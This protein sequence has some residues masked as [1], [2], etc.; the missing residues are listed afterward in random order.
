MSTAHLRAV[1]ES[2]PVHLS[3]GTTRNPL[4][5]DLDEN[6]PLLMAVCEGL[7]LLLTAD[8]LDFTSLLNNAKHL[9]YLID[10]ATPLGEVSPAVYVAEHLLVRYGI[11]G[12]AGGKRADSVVSSCRK[13]L[14]PF[15]VEVAWAKPSSLRGAAHLR[16]ADAEDLP[17][18]LA[19]RKKLPAAVVAARRLGK[20]RP[21][22]SCL[23]L[24]LAEAAH[25]VTG[26][27]AVLQQAITD[28]RV[29]TYNDLRTGIALV[30]P[31]S[32]IHI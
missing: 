16:L 32:L 1:A 7:P 21:A 8:E 14:I 20:R 31:L 6:R 23:H 26:G 28:G 10:P 22:V 27:A 24:D 3:G 5:T 15:L 12:A 18:I 30:R 17:R 19:G 29:P 2:D 13:Y 4:H 9:N 11:D 25:V